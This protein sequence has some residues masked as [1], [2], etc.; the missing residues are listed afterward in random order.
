MSDPS[1]A[2][3][4]GTSDITGPEAQQRLVLVLENLATAANGI[5]QTQNDLTTVAQ[6]TRD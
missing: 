3:P 2:Q 1:Q 6:T 5:L 4:S